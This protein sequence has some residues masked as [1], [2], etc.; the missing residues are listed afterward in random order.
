MKKI[1]TKI[2]S[3]A[4]AQAFEELAD[5]C[6]SHDGS[7]L[8]SLLDADRFNLLAE[9]TPDAGLLLISAAAVFEEDGLW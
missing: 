9:D 2:L 8:P 1:R 5:L 7:S 4:Q 3:A 6:R